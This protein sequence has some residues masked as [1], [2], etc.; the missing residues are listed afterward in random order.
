MGVVFLT[1]QIIGNNKLTLFLSN[2]ELE[3][4]GLCKKSAQGVE[5][6]KVV[7][8]AMRT[9]GVEYCGDM[10]IEMFNGKQGVLIFAMVGLVSVV[11][12]I[13][14]DDLENLIE[15]VGTLNELPLKS[16]L[17][18]CWDKYW[19]EIRDFNEIAE[20]VSLLLGE[21]GQHVSPEDYHEGVLEEYG[22]VIEED[23]AI[24][25]FRL[26]FHNLSR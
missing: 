18:Y 16:K 11:R 4:L 2:D 9:L 19:L 15:A 6:K 26:A 3:D 23:D 25:K 21:Y 7:V 10:E 14:F 1:S 12:H 5:M 8:E 22:T 13:V 20:R 24:M 17:T